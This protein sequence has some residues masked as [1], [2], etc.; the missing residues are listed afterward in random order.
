MGYADPEELDEPSRRALELAADMLL[1]EFSHDA[2]RTRPS[3]VLDPDSTME[4]SS[5]AWLIVT[6]SPISV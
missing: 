4:C 1:D 5:S 6:S 3:E 2:C